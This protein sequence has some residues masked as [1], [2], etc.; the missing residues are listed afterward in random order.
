MI[1][2]EIHGVRFDVSY[3]YQPEEKQVNY[4]RDGSG[5]P[6]CPESIEITKIDHMGTDFVGFF[7]ELD[8]IEEIEEMILE[9]I[10]RQ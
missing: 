4:Y 9:K 1:F 5:Y 7:E 8:M 6:G 3:D 10:H 2:L